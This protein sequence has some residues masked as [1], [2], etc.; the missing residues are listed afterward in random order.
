MSALR[1]DQ[2]RFARGSGFT[3]AC[4][5]AIAAGERVALM[6][7]SGS[8][9]T[10][11]LDLVAGFAAPDSGRIL[12]DGRDMT[13]EPPAARPVSM[14]FQSDNL[15]G[16][17]DAFANV[18]LGVSP[19]LKLTAD[20]R[21]AV[22]NAL[23]EVGLAGKAARRPGQLSGGERQRV[24]I[25]RLLVR[26]KP[27][28]LLDEPFASLGPA[29]ATDML[30]LVSD[31]ASRTGAAVILVTHDPREALR[32]ATR[33][34]FLDVGTVAYDGPSAELEARGGEAVRRY[35]GG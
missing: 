32:F 6:G 15:F 16:H 30:D 27:L 28:L 31:V 7:A 4:D 11:I 19:A 2:I 12:F 18:G 17:L 23:G 22:E 25:A 5:F 26:R 35:L 13:A 33:T 24:A 1:L 8:G 10:T 14:L 34:I 21:R 29:L 20:D 9:K 3:L